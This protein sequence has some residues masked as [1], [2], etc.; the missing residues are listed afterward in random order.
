MGNA[1]QHHTS[2]EPDQR[3]HHGHEQ[4]SHRTDQKAACHDNKRAIFVHPAAHDWHHQPLQD[5]TACNR[6][7]YCAFVDTEMPGQ[8]RFRLGKG[9]EQQTVADDLADP[10]RMKRNGAM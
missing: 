3:R 1:D 9:I 2:P 4:Q 5:Q 6:R 8:R 10:K 7:Q